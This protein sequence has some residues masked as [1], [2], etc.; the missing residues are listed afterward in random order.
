MG[1][2]RDAEGRFQSDL[3]DIPPDKVLLSF[4]DLLARR[5]LEE[6]AAAYEGADLEFSEDIQARLDSLQGTPIALQARQVWRGAQHGMSLVD[7]SASE[8]FI[9]GWN[10]GV[11]HALKALDEHLGIVAGCIK[12]KL[13]FKE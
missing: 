9:S 12:R 10:A 6:L 3:H 8:G 4:H 7:P 11:A 13:T 1:H 5:A 2:H